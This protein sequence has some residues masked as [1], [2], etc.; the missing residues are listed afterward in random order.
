MRSFLETTGALLF[1][2]TY[3]LGVFAFNAV[4]IYLLWCAGKAILGGL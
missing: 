2:V 3:V 4:M 1:G